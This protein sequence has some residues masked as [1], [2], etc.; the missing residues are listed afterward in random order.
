MSS[1]GG[2]QTIGYWYRLL[3]AFGLCLGPIDAFL[4]FRA[5]GRT[6]WKG[7]VTSTTRI[8]VNAGNLFGG[9]KKE[10][11]L[12][13]EMDI[14]FG[15][16]TQAANDYLRAVLGTDQPTYRGKVTAVWRGGRWGAMNP[17]PKRAEFKVRRILKG[18]DDDQ[19]WYPEKAEIVMSEVISAIDLGPESTGW[20]YLITTL[21]DDA[22]Y[23]SASFNDGSW[24]EGQTPFA[25][26]SDHPF[27]AAAGFPAIS[28]TEWP[29][30]SKIWIRRKFD[31]GTPSE[32]I[33]TLF[34]DN[35]ASVWV[36]DTLLL[37]RAGSVTTPSGSI[38]THQITVPS[39]LLIAG[40]N[41]IVLV[42]EDYGLYSYAA[43]KVSAVGSSQLIGINAAHILYDSLTANDMQG[44]PVDLVD[45]DSFRAA[46]DRLYSEGMGLCTMYGDEDID[47][48]QER[49]LNVIGASMSQS[50]ENGRYYLDLIRPTLNIDDLVIITSDDIVDLT[51][52]PTTLSEMVNQVSVKWFDPE[53]KEARQTAPFQNLG[54]I[55]AAGRP[56]PEQSDYPEVPYEPLALRL[57]ARDAQA[58]G[59]PLSKLSMTTNRRRDIW[60]LRKGQK[61]RVQVPED[62][63]SDMVCVVGDI[64]V[65]TLKDGRIKLKLVQDVYS[66]PTTVYVS[67]EPGQAPPINAAP[68]VSPNQ[69]LIEAPYV[70]LVAN[71][72]PADRS[73]FPDDAGVIMAMATQPTSGL[74]YGL[75]TAAEGL[76]LVDNGT[77]EWCPSAL[78]VEE[79][80]RLTEH[81]AL[82]G[83]SNLVDVEIGTWALWDDEIVR[84]D[85]LNVAALT[86][87]IGRGCADTV[88]MIHDANSRIWFCGDWSAS[89]QL[90]Y[91]DGGTIR[92]RLPTRS[93]F[94]ELPLSATPELAIEMHQRQLRP[95]PPAMV[96]VNGHVEPVEQ[97]GDLVI[98]WVW[99]DRLMQSDRLFDQTVGDIGPESGTS[100]TVRVYRSAVLME[101]LLGLTTSP[102]TYTPPDQS[103]SLRIEVETVRAGLVSAQMWVSEFAYTGT[104]ATTPEAVSI[105]ANLV[106][107]WPFDDTQSD[108]K[109]SNSFSGT[110]TYDNGK[111]GK[112]I[113]APVRRSTTKVGVGNTTLGGS[114]FGWI[115]LTGNITRGI[116]ALGHVGSSAGENIGISYI[117][118]SGFQAYYRNAANT[119]TQ[120]TETGGRATGAWYFLSAVW[121][122]AAIK[123][124]VDGALLGTVAGTVGSQKVSTGFQLG[125]PFSNTD[126]PGHLDE[127]G[128][129]N[130]VLTDAE[131]AYLYNSGNGRSYAQLLSDAGE[132]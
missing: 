9:E 36:N 46:A 82:T 15:D 27:S 22:D 71:L 32:I 76:D 99:R 75:Y 2:K 107:W 48:F 125:V 132:A 104:A 26:S 100:V 122:G 54:A 65:G 8:F 109:G 19:P 58:R 130:A 63:I 64:D 68:T 5:G 73:F 86:L 74:N 111:V 117:S 47:Q 35:L 108:A 29:L 113:Q 42:G 7:L 12:T 44:E 95:Y 83:G 50:R 62:G 88:P 38:F 90:E 116:F 79:A 33:L 78:I 84:I 52:E 87:Q 67:P 55:Q 70:E 21:D 114:L 41:T 17:Y 18:W 110:A 105:Y 11:G 30:N 106:S 40:E 31:V 96:T 129:T 77:G 45:D 72:T 37:D 94:A 39:A 3:Q 49:I 112:A 101:T 69:R 20:R 81:F 91:V 25:S 120:F 57:C 102:V 66:M 97:A 4:E 10:G 56:I 61:V 80:D 13:G 51:I 89:D 1:G 59:T 127:W 103:G 119:V 118:G 124:Y 98:A 115:C 28:N 85:A 34:V 23:S 14:Q 128:Y 123:L 43:F 131:V 53:R 126:V 92:A 16:T 24:S 93:S 6:A 121:T 60:K